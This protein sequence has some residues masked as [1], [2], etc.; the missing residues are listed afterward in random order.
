MGMHGNVDMSTRWPLAVTATAVDHAL[1]ACSNEQGAA[2]TLPYSRGL[3]N[4]KLPSRSSRRV[5]LGS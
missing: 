5:L 2:T 4:V 1:G 3:F